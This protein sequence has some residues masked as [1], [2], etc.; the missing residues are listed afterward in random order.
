MHISAVIGGTIGATAVDRETGFLNHNETEIL[1][2]RHHPRERDGFLDTVDF[3]TQLMIAI[4]RLAIDAHGHLLRIVQGLD[5][6]HIGERFFRVVE[7]A[8][9]SLECT[10]ISRRAQP[11]LLG[12]IAA[13]MGFEV[14]FPGPRQTRHAALEFVGVGLGVVERVQ[15]DNEMNPGQRTV[16]ELRIIGR[17]TPVEGIADQLTRLFTHFRIITVTRHIEQRRDKTVELVTADEQLGTRPVIEVQHAEADLEQII[18]IGLKQLIAR[19]ILDGITQLLGVVRTRRLAGTLENA[20]NLA[21]DQRNRAGALIIGFC[22]EQADE[23][24]FTDHGTVLAVPLD[25]D[26]IHVDATVDARLHIGLGHDQR[27]RFTQE[28]FNRR[29][30]HRRF[31][32]FAQDV[33]IGVAK[34][35][36]PGLLAHSWV[37][38]RHGTVV[39]D[40]EVVDPAAQEGEMIVSQPAQEFQRFQE[41]FRCR[42]GRR[43]FQMRDGLIH[44]GPHIGP[45]FHRDTD[46]I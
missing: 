46:I 13:D 9:S 35:T 15:A 19:I 11:D 39:I 42:T 41:L 23:A 21:A 10:V 36:A 24:G 6:E 37:P 17:Q 40:L 16:A 8:I 22:C 45:V 43:I 5:L 34:H 30:Q 18:L 2:N 38:V 44:L 32:P 33:A 3:Q 7:L 28:G 14:V 20:A 4:I 29:R 25:A 12:R 31:G 1:Q 26:I 27:R